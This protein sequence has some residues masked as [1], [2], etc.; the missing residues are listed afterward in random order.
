MTFDGSDQL[1]VPPLVRRFDVFHNAGDGESICLQPDVYA[2]LTKP[3]MR[4]QVHA[5]HI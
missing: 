1:Q 5:L 4:S 2:L 3:L